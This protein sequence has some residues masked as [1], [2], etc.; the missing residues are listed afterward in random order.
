MRQPPL[1]VLL[2]LILT[3]RLQQSLDLF[4]ASKICLQLGEHSNALL[5]I[6]LCPVSARLLHTVQQPG[7]PLPALLFVQDLLS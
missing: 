7:L 5:V 2:G 1:L 6:L 4:L 3:R